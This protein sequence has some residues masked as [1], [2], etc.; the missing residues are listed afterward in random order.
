MM[1]SRWLNRNCRHP[2][3]VND[4]RKNP[5]YPDYPDMIRMDEQNMPMA[6]ADTEKEL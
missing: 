2:E 6:A 4:F 3:R 1:H 5:R